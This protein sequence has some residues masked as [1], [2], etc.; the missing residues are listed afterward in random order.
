M[1]KVLVVDDEV[2][3]RK[4]VAKIISEVEGFS[5]IL[6]A[7]NG[8]EAVDICNAENIDIIFMDIMMP[9]KDGITASKEI[10]GINPN[11]SIYIISSYHSFELA[12]EALKSKVKQYIIKPLK[13]E[14]IKNILSNFRKVEDS[15]KIVSNTDIYKYIYDYDFKGLYSK[16]PDIC[17]ELK[18]K[19]KERNL[20]KIANRFVVLLLDEFFP[21]DT[22]LTKE[23]KEKLDFKTSFQNDQRLLFLWLFKVF[24]YVF[25]ERSCDK[26]TILSAIYL[27]I[28]ENI[29]KH[30][31]LDDIV[32]DCNVSQGYLSRILKKELNMTVM[33]YIHIKKINL[34]KEYI[35]IS[36]L[37]VSEIYSL[38]GYNE[39]S[40]FCKLFKKYENMTVSE[41][42]HIGNMAEFS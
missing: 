2:I 19:Y 16:I 6:F 1:Y 5:T 7:S 24:E 11:I 9:R 14:V 25:I 22:K 4:A 30:I 42:R 34:A 12:Q 39:F 13:V 41:F 31:S 23:I 38:V 8:Q 33:N 37:G 29:R 26:Y 21:K 40:Y 10:L 15:E 20:K 3:M 35:C 32:K 17:L 28:E 27:Y 36:R 18:E